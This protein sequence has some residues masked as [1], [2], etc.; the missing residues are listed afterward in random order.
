MLNPYKII[1]ESTNHNIQFILHKHEP[2][3]GSLHYDLRFVDPKN[4]KLLH[5]FACPKNFLETLN[6]K[7]SIVKTRDHDVRWLTLQSYRMKTIDSGTVTYKVSTAKYFDIT[8]HG[9]ILNGEYR[10]FKLSRTNRDDRWLMI[11]KK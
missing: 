11:R 5:S 8:F 6:T 3:S 4:P 2:R 9:K 7:S 1:C 10:L